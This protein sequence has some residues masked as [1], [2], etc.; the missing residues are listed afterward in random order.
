MT[1]PTIKKCS[2]FYRM[3]AEIV[4]LYEVTP[5]E[6][7]KHLLSFIVNENESIPY[8]IKVVLEAL[9]NDEK[10]KILPKR[11]YKYKELLEDEK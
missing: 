11:D 8:R 6:H 10:I 5:K 1:K 7:K 2:D 3:L 9:K 4:D